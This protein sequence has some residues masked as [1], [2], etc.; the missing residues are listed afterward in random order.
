M[1]VSLSAIFTAAL[2]CFGVLVRKA[3]NVDYTCDC[4]PLPIDGSTA[5]NIDYYIFVRV[6]LFCFVKE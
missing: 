1:D 5:H 2:C 3:Y 4:A 6:I